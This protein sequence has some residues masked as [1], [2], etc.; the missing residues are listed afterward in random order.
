MSTHEVLAHKMFYA[1]LQLKHP[2]VLKVLEPLE[3]TGGQMVM[4]TEPIFGSLTNVLSQFNDVPTA[5]DNRAGVMFS[6]LELKYGLYHIAETLHFLH[7]EAKLAHCNINPGSVIIAWNGSWKLAGFEHFASIQEFAIAGNRPQV[8]EYTSAHPSPW[9]EYRQPPLGYTAPELVGGCLSSNDVALSGAADCFSLAA[10]TYQLVTGKVLLPVGSSTGNY[11]SRLSGLSGADMSGISGSL[12]PLLQAML[13]MQTSAR[14]NAAAY[15]GCQWFAED[16]LLR[17]LK[18]VDS[19]LQRDNS[20]KVNFL[21]DLLGMWQQFDDR[22]LQ[23]HILPPIVSEM[24]NDMVA[25]AALPVVLAIM[26]RMK[27]EGFAASGIL[28]V[29]KPIFE[30]ADGEVLLA[31][32]R[33]LHVF[34]NLMPSDAHGSVLVPLMLRAF[35]SNNTKA[36]EETLKALQKLA[37]DMPYTLL[38]DQ[39]IPRV[40]ALCLRT[41]SLV[42][43]VSGLALLAEAAHRLDKDTAGLM[44][45]VAGQVVAVDKSA[46]T[47][48]AV[49]R[50]GDAVGK[51]YGPEI[52][53]VRVL[54]L[55]CPVLVSA[56]LNQQQFDSYMLVVRAL[57]DQVAAKRRGELAQAPAAAGAGM[58]SAV[59]DAGVSSG[60]SIGVTSPKLQSS[61]ALPN[62]PTAYISSTAA[63]AIYGSSGGSTSPSF[64]AADGPAAASWDTPLAPSSSSSSHVGHAAAAATGAS[65]STAAW[66]SSTVG[67]VSRSISSSTSNQQ[68]WSSIGS[69][70]Q[71]PQPWQQQQQQ[72]PSGLIQQRRTSGGVGPGTPAPDIFSSTSSSSGANTSDMLGGLTA[73]SPAMGSSSSVADSTADLFGGLA[74]SNSANSSKQQ[75]HQPQQPMALK[76]P[77]SAPKSINLLGPSNGAFGSDSSTSTQDPFARLAAPGL[78]ASNSNRLTDSNTAT[79]AATFEPFSSLAAAGPVVGGQGGPPAADP[80]LGL[81]SSSTSSTPMNAAKQRQ[82]QQRQQQHGNGN[83]FGSLI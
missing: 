33:H 76:P 74:V 73:V 19:I 80:F 57:L 81:L 18:F 44:L 46:G 79:S 3:E 17:C 47:A 70:R 14:P 43:R 62:G 16:M 71:P 61:G 7:Q 24:R 29:L 36:Q 28:P 50:L 27:P 54:P 66:N 23:H 6:P 2:G 30:H 69:P 53:A 32:V 40:V 12:Q 9:E 56:G 68:H 20:Q 67:P 64:A 48:M 78:S 45:D 41:T 15:S 8:F 38:K 77:P 1:P 4:I 82:H 72:H 35:D 13:S 11:R 60:S 83:D 25:L 59:A 37:P 52:T 22:L 31:L 55:L 5:P 39:L 10:L 51:H 34:Y 63:A 26:A 75:G 42:V 21:K 65:W 49:L 58:N